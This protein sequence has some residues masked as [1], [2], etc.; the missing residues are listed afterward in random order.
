[1]NDF[2]V[3]VVGLG[4]LY[5]DSL[6]AYG[7]GK[8]TTR[9]R[10]TPTPV[11]LQKL[12]RVF[13]EGIGTP[14]KQK[15]K[16]LTAELSQHGPISETNVYNWFQN[17]RARSKRK[18][19]SEVQNNSEPDVE[20]ESG[21]SEKTTRSADISNIRDKAE[22]VAKDAYIHDPSTHNLDTQ[23]GKGKSSFTSGHNT[24]GSHGQFTI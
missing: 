14:S 23:R 22:P 16:D 17:R 8:I 6:M 2:F 15:I 12:E 3:S 18:Q 9:H 11:Q 1:M 13:E 24:Y 21:S 10:W 7:A 4:N 20:V 19:F 5:C